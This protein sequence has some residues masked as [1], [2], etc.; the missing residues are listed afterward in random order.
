MS[1]AEEKTQIEK[2]LKENILKIFN[3]IKTGCQRKICYNV[4][5]HKNLICSES[6][7]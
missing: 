1:T 6:N 5:C 2:Q 3:Q 7:T 4:Y